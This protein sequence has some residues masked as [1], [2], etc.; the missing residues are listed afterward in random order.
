[1]SNFKNTVY[2]ILNEAPEDRD[3]RMAREEAEAEVKRKAAFERRQAKRKAEIDNPRNSEGSPEAKRTRDLNR[4]QAEAEADEKFRRTLRGEGSEKQPE[5]SSKPTPSATPPAKPS[6]TP[7]TPTPTP[8][9]TPSA[10][11]PAKPSAT[12]STPTPTPA[13][14]STEQPTPSTPSRPQSGGPDSSS[15]EN[16]SNNDS[17]DTVDA[18]RPAGD[19]LR[20]RIR[21]DQI[22]PMSKGTSAALAAYQQSLINRNNVS[23][24]MREDVGYSHN[25]AL[26]FFAEQLKRK[27]IEEEVVNPENQPMTKSEISHRDKIRGKSPAK[28]AKAIKGSDTKENAEYR[29]A[30]Y[31]TMRGRK[32]KKKENK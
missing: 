9:P 24:T 25:K 31:I 27:Y 8:T 3:T 16:T 32:G 23:S 14:A 15:D 2:S 5:S 19:A 22:K 7:S 4:R 6:A 30:T 11:P 13:S 18:L 10:T 29:L 12:P 28:D 20:R 26:T 17:I 21:Q 1:M